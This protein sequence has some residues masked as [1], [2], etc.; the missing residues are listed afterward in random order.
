MLA[1]CE[2][3]WYNP[4]PPSGGGEI[5]RARSSC[6]ALHRGGVA[7]PERLVLPSSQGRLFQPRCRPGHP[8]LRPGLE[9]P[10]RSWSRRGGRL[11][12]PGGPESLPCPRSGSSETPRIKGAARLDTG[13]PSSALSARPTSFTPAQHPSRVGHVDRPR[14]VNARPPAALAEAGDFFHINGTLPSRMSGRTEVHSHT[15]ENGAALRQDGGRCPFAP[16]ADPAPPIRWAGDPADG[17]ASVVAATGA[18]PFAPKRPIPPPGGWR[19]RA[20]PAGLPQP[21]APL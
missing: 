21:L 6:G 11:V 3:L 12:R 2:P 8:G 5:R 15:R 9:R 16:A 18:G 17:H 13:Q 7:P 20:A 19:A 4:L 1:T 10:R 14:P